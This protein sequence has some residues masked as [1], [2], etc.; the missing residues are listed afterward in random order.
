MKK[1]KDAKFPSEFRLDLVNGDWVIIATGRARKPDSFKHEKREKQKVSKKD[2]PFCKIETQEDPTLIS[3]NSRKFEFEGWDKLPKNWTAIVIPNKYPALFPNPKLE[4]KVEGGMYEKINAVGFHEVVIT[5][6]HDKHLGQ[7]SVKSVKEVM[8]MY[9][10]RY[11]SL[12]K[13][14][15]VNHISI[16]HNKG[17]KAG[18]SVAHPH[19]Q[20]ITTPLIDVDLENALSKSKSYSRKENRC[21]YCKMN[22]WEIKSKKRIVFQNKDFLVLCPFASKTA[23][24]VIISPKQH[25][26]YYE[27]ITEDQKWT[28]AEAFQTALKKLRKGLNDPDYNF[29]LHTAPSDNKKHDYYHWHWTILPK[30]GTWAGFEMGTK[31]EI[32]TIEP[33]EAAKYLKKQ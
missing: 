32:S 29:Y 17:P 6:D 11:L 20:I 18:A 21:I 13:E 3:V 28:L 14:K 27:K 10:A 33:E 24:E 9:Q 19:S 15:F 8:D 31:M 30:T 26:P 1:R 4:K 25:L 5:R 12:M 16:F 7:M 2:C 22:D 23:F